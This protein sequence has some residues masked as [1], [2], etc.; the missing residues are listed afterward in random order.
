[1]NKEEQKY[2][3]QYVGKQVRLIRTIEKGRSQEKFAEDVDL[4]MS[5]IVQMEGAGKVPRM[6]TLVKLRQ[7]LN[8]SIDQWIDEILAESDKS[9]A[10]E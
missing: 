4:S 5:Q 6:D 10:D 7:H 1:M 2:I 8:V 3:A 9:Q